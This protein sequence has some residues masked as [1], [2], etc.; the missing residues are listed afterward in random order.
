MLIDFHTHVFPDRI[1]AKT[2]DVLSLKSG[3]LQPSYDGT[4]SGLLKRMEDE[5]VDKSVAL[6]IATNARQMKSVNDFAASINGEK[7]IAFGSVFP[8][9]PDSMEELERIKDLGLKGIKF[10]PEYQN[11]YVDEEKMYPI[12]KK[13][14]EL[15]L[16]TVFHAGADLGY[17]SP[18]HCTPDRAAKVVDK[19]TSPVVF[20]H[21]GG[22]FMG[23]EVLERL[24]GSDAFFDL[25][26]GYGSLPREVAIQIVEK[27]G[28]DKLLIGSDGPWHTIAAEKRFIDTLGLSGDEKDRIFY[29]NAKKLLRLS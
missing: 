7:I 10:H 9:S 11:F 13:A 3:G 23:E 24:A 6:G 25:S 19:F 15:G 5:C 29:K 16:I 20:A 17:A 27:H 1:A 8:D 2:I 4:V 22:Y 26:F 18:Y 21:W 12:Y 28:T 14:S